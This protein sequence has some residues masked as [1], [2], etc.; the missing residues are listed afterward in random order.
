MQ[1][2]LQETAD[3]EP[4]Q[5]AAPLQTIIDM[6]GK[7][8]RLVTNLEHLN[9][10]LQRLALSLAAVNGA[11]RLC[12]ASLLA[13]SLTWS[14]RRDNACHTRSSGLCEGIWPAL[15]L[16]PWPLCCCTT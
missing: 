14:I 6:R 8:A 3:R 12:G 7:Q 1:E 4:G 11:S 2:V 16:W 5:P 10:S 9:V 13:W 15:G